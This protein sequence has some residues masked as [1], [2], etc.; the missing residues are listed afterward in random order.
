MAKHDQ[1]FI[2]QNKTLK[3][4]LGWDLTCKKRIFI[5]TLGGVIFP[6]GKLTLNC[7]LGC[8]EGWQ[9]V[10]DGPR[11][12]LS[13]E[14]NNARHDD[15]WLVGVWLRPISKWKERC[16]TW[17]WPQS[18][19]Q[20]WAEKVQHVQKKMSW[21]KA[22]S[23]SESLNY[24]SK[25]TT[26]GWGW[27]GIPSPVQQPPILVSDWGGGR[28]L[29][30]PY[31]S[32]IKVVVRQ[33]GWT[34]RKILVGYIA[35]WDILTFFGIFWGRFGPLFEIV[36]LYWSYLTISGD[37]WPILFL[38]NFGHLPQSH[39]LTAILAI[40]YHFLGAIFWHLQPFYCGHPQKITKKAQKYASANA[41]KKANWITQIFLQLSNQHREQKDR[42]SRGVRWTRCVERYTKSVPS[43][44]EVQKFGWI[45]D[46]SQRNLGV[47]FQKKAL[48]RLEM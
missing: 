18:G 40:C 22:T 44:T 34:P 47:S 43:K 2:I 33:G 39:I 27:L 48:I 29:R 28:S 9:I 36:E 12:Q 3:K 1:P 10:K 20:R 31:S 46:K 8:S 7:M 37:F 32:P 41:K 19:G 13:W 4:L 17:G 45:L 16:L 25:P 30:Q 11:V 14:Q 5:S 21:V 38:A 26:K 24:E 15:A 42:I 6:P 35:I 23:P